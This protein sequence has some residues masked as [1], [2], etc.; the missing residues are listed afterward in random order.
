[1]ILIALSKKIINIKNTVMHKI[2]A[3]VIK[4]Y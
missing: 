3:F 2:Q 1:M 4:I